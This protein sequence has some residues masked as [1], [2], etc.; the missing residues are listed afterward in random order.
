M[1]LC[2]TIAD[3]MKYHYFLY[4]FFFFFFFLQEAIIRR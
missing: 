3:N 2:A 4:A 1:Q